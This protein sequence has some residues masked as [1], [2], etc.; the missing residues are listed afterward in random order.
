V[1][2][3]E[4]QVLDQVALNPLAAEPPL[5][6]EDFTITTAAEVLNH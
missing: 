3:Q 4:Q 2:H 5:E 6:F 1:L